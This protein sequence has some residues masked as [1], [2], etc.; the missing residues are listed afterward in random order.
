MPVLLFVYVLPLHGMPFSA[1]DH[2]LIPSSPL[3]IIS[4]RSHHP[5]ERAKLGATVRAQLPRVLG[6]RPALS[7]SSFQHL[8]ENVLV[9]PQGHHVVLDMLDIRAST[10]GGQNKHLAQNST[11]LRHA[12][13][14]HRCRPSVMARAQTG[15]QL[16]TAEHSCTTFPLPRSWRK[17]VSMKQCAAGRS[18]CCWPGLRTPP[19]PAAPGLTLQHYLIGEVSAAGS[20]SCICV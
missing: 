2:N 1:Y 7:V 12:F 16:M 20:R 13:G 15:S 19:V 10:M 14:R 18:H 8:M 9:R 11:S 4:P 6:R 3:V 5:I 17:L